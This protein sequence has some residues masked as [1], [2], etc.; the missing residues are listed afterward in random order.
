MFKSI[1]K[2]IAQEVI[3]ESFLNNESL[4]Y[5]SGLIQMAYELCLINRKEK[6]RLLN[7]AKQEENKNGI[8][9]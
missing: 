9:Q 5:K 8:I 1:N 2:R 7:E 4:E 3:T 6:E